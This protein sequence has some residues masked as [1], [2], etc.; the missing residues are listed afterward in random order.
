MFLNFDSAT[1]VHKPAPPTRAPVALG[2]GIS[3]YLV[4]ILFVSAQ[5]VVKAKLGKL[6]AE[7]LLICMSAVRGSSDLR[8]LAC[9]DRLFRR[10]CCLPS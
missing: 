9:A 3:L 7:D 2:V 10:R 4:A 6:G 8:V 5:I 1:P